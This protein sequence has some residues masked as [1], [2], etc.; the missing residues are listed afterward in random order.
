MLLLV[1]APVPVPVLVA[2][3]KSSDSTGWRMSSKYE[4][5]PS[6]DDDAAMTTSSSLDEVGDSAVAVPSVPTPTR[7]LRLLVFRLLRSMRLFRTESLIPAALA[8]GD[9]GG[10]TKDRTGLGSLLLALPAV[11]E[12]LR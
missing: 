8:P 4:C 1:L 10:G 2:S 11:G 3:P 9:G 12:A 7:G 5:A 6:A